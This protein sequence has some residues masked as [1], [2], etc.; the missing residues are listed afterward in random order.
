MRTADI[1]KQLQERAIILAGELAWQKE[2]AQ[3]A[4][5]SLARTGCAVLGVEIWEGSSGEGPRVLGWSE[6]QIDFDGDWNRFVELNASRAL[7]DVE[8]A[9]AP[10]ELINLTWVSQDDFLGNHTSPDRHPD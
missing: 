1:P 3:A 2:D 6:Y 7:Q 8:K 5:L 9:T 10:N 4:I